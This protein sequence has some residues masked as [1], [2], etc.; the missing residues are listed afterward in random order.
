MLSVAGVKDIGDFVDVRA[1]GRTD[2]P[3]LPRLVIVVD[4]FASLALELPDFLKGLVGIA[5]R[6][7]SLGVHLVLATQRP[8]GVIS[9]EIR[10]NANF[11][12]A[13]RV[14]NS[15]ESSDIIGAPNAATFPPPRR[16]RLPPHIAG[17]TRVLP[18]RPSGRP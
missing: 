7:R 15:S 4:E 9:P 5:Q 13:L 12:I 16:A 11:A 18:D 10:A 6:G 17:A 2:L 3:P 1:R 8:T 14:V